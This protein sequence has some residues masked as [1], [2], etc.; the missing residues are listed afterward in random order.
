KKEDFGNDGMVRLTGRRAEHIVKILKSAKGDRI[1][2]GLLNGPRGESEV[3]EIEND[4]VLVRPELLKS[5]EKPRSI[6]AVLAMIR[7]QALRRTL[8]NLAVFGV[9]DIRLINSAKVEKQYFGQRL[10]HD[11]KFME[12]F[13]LGLEQGAHTLLPSLNIHRSFKVFMEEE[14]DRCSGDNVRI[15]AHPGEDK[16]VMPEENKGITVAI[17]P[18]GGWTEYEVSVF[19]KKGFTVIPL[20]NKILKT[21]TAVPY[22]FGKLGI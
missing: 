9:S 5:C 4:S 6:T 7:P 20:G 12:C 19:R 18:E 22:L 1:K 11:D 14:L 10:L 17:G 13:Y 8:I 15:L 3:I 2:C 21:E 16:A